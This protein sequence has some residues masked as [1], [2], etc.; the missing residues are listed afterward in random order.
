[1]HWLDLR[2]VKKKKDSKKLEKLVS[3]GSPPGIRSH[4]LP[5]ILPL[6]LFSCFGVL[7][8][9]SVNCTS[10]V[11]YL[12][13]LGNSLSTSLSV[14]TPLGFV[15]SQC[16]ASPRVRCFKQSHRFSPPDPPS[17]SFSP[18]LVQ[19]RD[20]LFALVP[21]IPSPKLPKDTAPTA[22][23]VVLDAARPP[24]RPMSRAVRSCPP[25]SSLCITT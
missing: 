25:M 12:G 11:I 6:R 2:E 14:I 18:P 17:P 13:V 15:D 23:C 16:A 10:F 7:W 20:R 21:V 8:D 3:S 19:L 5:S 24:A 4:F 22:E 1:M 9:C